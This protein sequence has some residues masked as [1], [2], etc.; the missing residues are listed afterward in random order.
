[1]KTILVAT[2]FNKLKRSVLND[3]QVVKPNE[4]NTCNLPPVP[5]AYGGGTGGTVGNNIILCGGHNTVDNSGR[6]V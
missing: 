4:E 5:I 6:C 3:A 2:G 1:M